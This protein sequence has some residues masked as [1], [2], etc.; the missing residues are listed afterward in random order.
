[1]M[2]VYRAKRKGGPGST[3]RPIDLDCAP[4]ADKFTNGETIDLTTVARAA[5]RDVDT[6][7][8]A[9]PAVVHGV[10]ADSSTDR[11]DS[12]VSSADSSDADSV[13]AGSAEGDGGASRHSVMRELLCVGHGVRGRR[14]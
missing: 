1:M 13:S 4:M 9:S 5:G 3:G 6:S 11:P 8:L 12:G 2:V 14:S 7:A 10:G